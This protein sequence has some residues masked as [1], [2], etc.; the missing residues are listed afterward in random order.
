MLS[1]KPYLVTQVVWELCCGE[2]LS[3]DLVWLLLKTLAVGCL[4]LEIRCGA[5]KIIMQSDFPEEG[6][7]LVH[8]LSTLYQALLYKKTPLFNEERGC[9]ALDG[10]AFC[11]TVYFLKK[12]ALEKADVLE[13]LPLSFH[14]TFTRKKK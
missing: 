6:A 12:C 3:A 8:R 5:E 13:G 14:Y 2:W 10:S 1:T 4:E 11:L 9:G 7:M